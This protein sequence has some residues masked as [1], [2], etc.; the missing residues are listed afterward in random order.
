[1]KEQGCEKE[2]QGLR[3]ANE[4]SN[5]NHHGWL[6]IESGKNGPGN[7]AT[8]H[9]RKVNGHKSKRPVGPSF[10]SSPGSSTPGPLYILAEADHGFQ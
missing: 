6:Y 5:Y 10:K 8:Q 1:V 2:S 7:Q 3:E 4:A 9:A